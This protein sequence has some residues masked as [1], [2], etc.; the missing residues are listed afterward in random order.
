MRSHLWQIPGSICT[1]GQLSG[2]SGSLIIEVMKGQAMVTVPPITRWAL[3]MMK[4]CLCGL[5][6]QAVKNVSFW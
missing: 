6:H 5:C 3:P 4:C 1:V 2:L